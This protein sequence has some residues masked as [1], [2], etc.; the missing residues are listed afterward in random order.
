MDYGV[1]AELRR[2][3]QRFAPAGSMHYLIVPQEDVPLFSPFSG[4]DCVVWPARELLVPAIRLTPRLSRLSDRLPRIPAS[5]R[6]VAIE[7]RHPFPPIRGWILQQVLKLAAADRL[8]VATVLVADSD[9]EL[10]RPL[11]SLVFQNDGHTVLYRRD[12][13]VTDA[14][15]DHVRWHKSARALLGLPVAEPPYHDYISAFIAL[16]TAVVRQLRAHLERQHGTSWQQVIARQLNFSEWTLYG[17]FAD[18]VL[19]WR[20]N[21]ERHRDSSLCHEYWGSV[22]MEHAEVDEFVSKRRPDDIAMMISAKSHT[23][24]SVRRAASELIAPET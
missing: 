20:D 2:S 6:V 22:A 8:P 23:T 19:G 9:V 7:P 16:D 13:A 12:N 10:I 4:P 18:E 11:D 21:P 24:M 14:L 17:V 15:P 3:V 1:F 5:A